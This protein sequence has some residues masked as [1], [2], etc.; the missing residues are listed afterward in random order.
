MHLIFS[1]WILMILFL[2]EREL[3]LQEISLSRKVSFASYSYYYWMYMIILE[4]SLMVSK[5]RSIYSGIFRFWS[6]SETEQE[7]KGRR[8]LSQVIS[9]NKIVIF[10][11]SES[12]ISVSFGIVR[13]LRLYYEW[14][15]IFHYMEGYIFAVQMSLLVIMT[16]KH[17]INF[18]TM[19][20]LNDLLEITF[21]DLMKN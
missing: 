8:G 3:L 9:L 17:V 19:I 21:Q 2:F 7:D 4:Y 5:S 11:S 16:T 18:F 20:T 6:S 14:K 1:W 12:E 13:K 15:D 10:S